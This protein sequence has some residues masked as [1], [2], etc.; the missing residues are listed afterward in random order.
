MKSKLRK[1][2]EADIREERKAAGYYDGRFRTRVQEDKRKKQERKL[3][4]GPKKDWE[5]E[6]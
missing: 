2:I 4:R 6:T 3:T 5:S 1:K